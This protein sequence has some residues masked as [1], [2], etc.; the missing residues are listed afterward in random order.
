MISK[1]ET[2]EPSVSR[3]ASETLYKSLSQGMHAAAQPLAILRASFG[4]N[5]ME[6][7]S[8]E[9]L[10]ELAASSALEIERVCTLFS[11]LQQLVRV[12]SIEPHLSAAPILPLL[13]HV[14]DGV[15]LLFYEDGIFLR[16]MVPDTCPPVLINRTRAL[17]ALSGVLL[18]AHAVSQAQEAVELIASCSP[19]NT[20]RIVVRNLRSHVT[21]MNSEHSLNM[22][23]AEANIRS[24]QGRF[25]WSLEPFNVEIELQRAQLEN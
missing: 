9:E 14:V 16:S 20:V 3:S 11:C 22:A 21:A 5:Y 8:A 25:T 18:I 19:D 13:A 6:R 12:E 2:G 24:Q 1:G 10:R 17:E 4:N 7:M 15:K 23:L